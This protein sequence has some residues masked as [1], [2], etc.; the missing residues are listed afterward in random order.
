MP[1]RPHTP[2][3]LTALAL[4][5]LSLTTLTGCKDGQ[6]VRDEGPATNKAAAVS[7]AENQK[8]ARN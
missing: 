8:A 6:G 2:R 7:S 4:T 3:L 5:L 1:T